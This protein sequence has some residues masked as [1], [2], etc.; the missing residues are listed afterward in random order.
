MFEKFKAKRLN[1][2]VLREF[3]KNGFTAWAIKNDNSY[4]NVGITLPD[5]ATKS[6]KDG[7]KFLEKMDTIAK[8]MAEQY[9]AKFARTEPMFSAGGVYAAYLSIKHK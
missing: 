4:F 7:K 8:K 3:E 6:K 9:N 5:Y 2:Y 1:D